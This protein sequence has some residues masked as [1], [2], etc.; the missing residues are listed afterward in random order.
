MHCCISAH[1]F[2]RNGTGKQ[3]GTEA[4]GLLGLVVV[5]EVE[6]VVLEQ[7]HVAPVE[8]EEHLKQ[9]LTMSPQSARHLVWLHELKH[10]SDLEVDGF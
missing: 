6:L 8:L 10:M 7:R 2:E 9:S 1:G 4:G 5:D 3:D